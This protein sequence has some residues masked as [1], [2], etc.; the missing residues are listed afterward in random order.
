[1]RIIY[2]ENKFT[3][4][5]LL[6]IDMNASNVYQL[7]VFQVLIFISKSNH[8]LNQKLFDHMLVEIHD[9]YLTRFSRSYFKEP[10]INIE[11]I[12]FSIFS[13]GSKTC[14]MRTR[15]SNNDFIFV[16]IS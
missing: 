9:R 1:M 13:H 10:K 14:N 3:H 7:N 4:S 16:F 5:K 11:S 15:I 8:N 12:S 2:N 6:M